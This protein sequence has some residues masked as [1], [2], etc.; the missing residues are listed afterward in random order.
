[1]PSSSD[2]LTEFT[3]FVQFFVWLVVSYS[4]QKL[5]WLWFPSRWPVKLDEGTRT[6][7]VSKVGGSKRFW[8]LIRI[9]CCET[10]DRFEPQNPWQQVLRSF[11][12]KETKPGTRTQSLAIW[13]VLEYC[14]SRFEIV[15]TSNLNRTVL[16]IPFWDHGTLRHIHVSVPIVAVL[17]LNLVTSCRVEN[18]VGNLNSVEPESNHSCL[19]PDLQEWVP[20]PSTHLQA[21]AWN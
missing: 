5:F 17:H 6:L 15:V 3:D 12:P 20:R 11:H 4:Q 10:N 21:E 14:F 1:M 8:A 13:Q 16:R 2:L 18:F 19:V 9:R 7:F